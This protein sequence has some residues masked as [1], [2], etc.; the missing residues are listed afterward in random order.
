[1]RSSEPGS[2]VVLHGLVD[3]PRFAGFGR[4]VAFSGLHPVGSRV[5]CLV[6]ESEEQEDCG[7]FRERR[8]GGTDFD[9]STDGGPPLSE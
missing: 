2:G 4:C 6:P 5:A 7:D 3:G 8:G 9:R 1:M